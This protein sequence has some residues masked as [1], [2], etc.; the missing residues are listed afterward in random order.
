MNPTA[1]SRLGSSVHPPAATRDWRC[2]G[3]WL[4]GTTLAYNVLEGV[5]A[6]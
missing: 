5:L 1:R 2:I 4:V 6:L 3:L